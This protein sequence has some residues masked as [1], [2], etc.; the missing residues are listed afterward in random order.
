[1]ADSLLVRAV[2][3]TLVVNY[4][5][6][7]SGARRFIGRTFLASAGPNGGWPA[8]AEPAKVP[9]TAEYLKALRD[10]SL[11]PADEATAQRAGVK[12]DPAAEESAKKDAADF[13]K[14]PADEVPTKV[15]GIKSVPA[16]AD[17]NTPPKEV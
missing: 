9:A 14:E 12:W 4:E 11:A 3:A 2:G 10:G 7:E 16:P 13:W 1:M 5:A 15:E 6:L 8:S 17:T